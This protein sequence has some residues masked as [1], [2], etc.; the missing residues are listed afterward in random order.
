MIISTITTITNAAIAAIHTVGKDIGCLVSGVEAGS[1]EGVELGEGVGASAN[2]MI[3]MIIKVWVSLFE[4]NLG[5]LFNFRA[6]FVLKG[7]LSRFLDTRNMHYL[8]LAR[9]L[10]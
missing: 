5:S 4:G 3:S 8:F 9:F 10:D 2:V 7:F 6:V 1:W